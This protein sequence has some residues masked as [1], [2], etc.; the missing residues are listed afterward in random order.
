MPALP[1]DPSEEPSLR[2]S[3]RGCRRPAAVDL[4]WRNPRLHDSARLKHWLACADHAD[5]LAEFLSQRGFLLDRQP[6]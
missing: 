1:L 6:L 2:C 3:A 5:D 4:R